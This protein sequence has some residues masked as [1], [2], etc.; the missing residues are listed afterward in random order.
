MIGVFD[1][2]IG[3]LIVL[4]ALK[5]QIPGYDFI[6]FGD[7][8]R[9][10]YDTKSPETIIDYT[11]ENIE[12]LKHQGAK[13][14]VLA[15]NT[16]ASVA[17]DI[18]RERF[19]IPVFEGITPTVKLA[20]K[21]SRYQRIGIIGTRT[22]IISGIYKKKILDVNP[23]SKVFSAA[24]PLL[25]PLIEENWIKKPEAKMIVK[26]YLHPLKVR[27][28]DTLILGCFYYAILANIIKA[29]IGKRVHIIDSSIAMAEGLK[30]FLKKHGEIDRR[31]SKTGKSRYMVSDLTQHVEKIAKSAFKG[32]IR[33]EAVSV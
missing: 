11:L 27:Q 4:S 10:P 32:N 1:S 8:A 18:V 26:K 25:V 33:L 23:K 19:D 28:I 13:V 29:K 22:T 24:C 15:C 3:G 12:F 17:T 31:L 21:T 20:I 6:Y 5:K 14:I 30:D 9:A 16:V 7:T 2:G